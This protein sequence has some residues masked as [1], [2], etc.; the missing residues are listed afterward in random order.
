MSNDLVQFLRTRLD[1]DEWAAQ[2]VKDSAA[3]RTHYRK[4]MLDSVER[5]LRD[6]EGKRAI[7]DAYLPPGSDPHPGLPCTDDVEGDPD[8]EFYANQYPSDRGACVR[9]LEASKR[10]LHDDYVLRLLALRYTDH[11]DYDEAWRP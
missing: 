1:E 4:S 9:H 7:I 8:G 6:V 2:A 11:A 10:L 3:K 5:D